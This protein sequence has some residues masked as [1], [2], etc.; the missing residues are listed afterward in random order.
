[1]LNR[2]TVGGTRTRIRI[3]GPIEKAQVS[4]SASTSLARPSFVLVLVRQKLKEKSSKFGYELDR[5][6]GKLDMR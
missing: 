6:R 5:I 2:K 1:M 3:K 4:S